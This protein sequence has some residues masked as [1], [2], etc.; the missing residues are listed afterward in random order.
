MVYYQLIRYPEALSDV[1]KEVLVAL[2]SNTYVEP[3]HD[4]K[5]VLYIIS[6]LKNSNLYCKMFFF[7]ICLLFL[8]KLD[9]CGSDIRS[10]IYF[11]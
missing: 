8:N 10:I 11:L 7:C 9:L 1:M 5:N 2:S 4:V 3:A 6:Y